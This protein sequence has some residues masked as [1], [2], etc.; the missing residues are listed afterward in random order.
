MADGER[1]LS[2]EEMEAIGEVVAS[3]QLGEGYNVGLETT[4]FDLVSDQNRETFDTAFLEQVNE[5]LQRYL[6]LSIRKELN[7]LVDLKAQPVEICQYKKLLETAKNPSSCSVTRISP[8]KE[9][10]LVLFDSGAIFSCVDAWFGG[11]QK[12]SPAESE[13]RQFSATEDLVAKKMRIALY[14]ALIEAWAPALEVQ[15]EL[16]RSE[17]NAEL[18]ELFGPEDLILINRFLFGG[19]D[20]ALGTV[21]IVYP[22]ES[23]K[24]ARGSIVERTEKPTQ[25]NRLEKIWSRKLEE[26]VGEVPFE[27]V[28]E[29]GKVPVF[30]GD[31]ERLQVGDMIPLKNLESSE[32]KVNGLTL[33]NVEIGSRGGNTAIKVLERTNRE[34][35]A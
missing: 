13:T 8:L 19:E 27:V 22:L 2:D 29:A 14:S 35:V 10:C 6:K 11:V 17:T 20:N 7:Y 12:P 31:L 30:L 28:V 16:L 4:P 9:K 18:L 21:E 15:C 1:L 3:G 5:R 25:K 33:F 24:L 23:V 34:S 26:A 32:L